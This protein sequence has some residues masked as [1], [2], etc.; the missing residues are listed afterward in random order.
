M[1]DKDLKPGDVVC[2]N[3]INVYKK[4]YLLNNIDKLL[5][6]F[7]IVEKHSRQMG[8]AYARNIF[9]EE[10]F[11]LSYEDIFKVEGSSKNPIKDNVNPNHYKQGKIECI[12]AI[13]SATI[14]KKG[15][16]AVCTAN[17][18]KYLWRYE[19]KNGIEDVK[20]AKWYIE[21]LIPE[22]DN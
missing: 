15:L 3:P 9:T 2:L 6:R 18:I 21:K 7:F 17:V 11:Y 22:L 20:K 5:H 12:D 10:M 16:E 8:G 14:N 4:P 19:S 13:K 1:N